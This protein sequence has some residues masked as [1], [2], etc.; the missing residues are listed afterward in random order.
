MEAAMRNQQDV[1]KHSEGPSGGE[2]VETVIIGG[3]QA[4]LA[5]GSHLARRERPFLIRFLV[6]AGDRRWEADQVV[7]ASGA[8]Q[9]HRI[10]AFASEL[11]QG[12]VQLDTSHYRNLSQLRPG[13][14]LVVGAGNS[15]AEI[16]YE[17]SGAHQT[18]LSGPIPATSRCAPA[19]AGTGCSPRRSGGSPRA[20]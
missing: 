12:I 14:V 3:G 7:V 9:R 15:G 10:P 6:A 19:A 20:C 2:R 16:A 11:D 17:I 13:G 5:V 1:M 8:Y 4:G 18:W